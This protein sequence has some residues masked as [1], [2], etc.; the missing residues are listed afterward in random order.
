MNFIRQSRLILAR[1]NGSAHKSYGMALMKQKSE[2]HSWLISATSQ[3]AID[4]D[5]RHSKAATYP[6][7]GFT[8]IELLVAISILSILASLLF[9][10]L[11]SVREQIQT[12]T[13]MNNLRQQCLALKAVSNDSDGY[14]PYSCTEPAWGES[15]DN[16]FGWPVV[17]YTHASFLYQKGYLKQLDIFWCRIAEQNSTFKIG[18][19]YD[20]QSGSALKSAKRSYA[21]NYDLMPYSGSSQ[22][23]NPLI[24]D[25]SVQDPAAKVLVFCGMR[26]G[27]VDYFGS[28][29]G[30]SG[31]YMGRYAAWCSN[32]DRCS[33]VPR[34]Q[35]QCMVGF[36][37]GHVEK[38]PLSDL[39]YTRCWQQK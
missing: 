15:G 11:R 21:V 38:K 1:Q 29:Y 10:A 31:L 22:P 9:A 28:C 34:H 2:K 19:L 36:V 27:G 32:W 12:V 6:K 35:G 5:S 30:G 24:H 23:W 37:D 18:D 17:H 25:A 33:P 26:W 13:C 20:P 16:A 14:L 7:H 39:A 8:M 4:E 3:K